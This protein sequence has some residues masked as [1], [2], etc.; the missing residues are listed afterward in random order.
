MSP[1]APEPR[2]LLAASQVNKIDAS[3]AAHTLKR[4]EN[5]WAVVSIY[6][7]FA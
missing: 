3:D 6:M 5:R 4:M 2:L 7:A 1:V